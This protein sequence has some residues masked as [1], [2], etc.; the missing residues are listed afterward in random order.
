M[1]RRFSADNPGRIQA[2]KTVSKELCQ[3]QEATLLKTFARKDRQS[4]LL[5]L[6][7]SKKGRQKLRA[8]L[9]HFND[10]DQRYMKKIPEDQQFPERIFQLLA[11]RKASST[12]LVISEDPNLD[13]QVLLLSE[14]LDRI[15]GSG[16]GTLVGCPPDRLGYY[17]SEEPGER[18][19][20]EVKKPS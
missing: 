6:R 5:T 16:M 17:E 15:V 13:G 3:E 18:Y 12:C 8:R 20:L 14:V 19:L 11:A 10:L 2:Q 4:R 1:K 7:Q 9:A